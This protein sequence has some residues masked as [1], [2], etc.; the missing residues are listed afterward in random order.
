MRVLS[1]KGFCLS[2]GSA[3]SSNSRG[4]A[5]SVL[6]AMGIDHGRRMSSIRISM[7][8]GTGEDEVDLLCSALKETS[9]E[10]GINRS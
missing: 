2:A 3:C 4:K 7:G 9:R 10:L 5:E 6:T 8:S 1:D